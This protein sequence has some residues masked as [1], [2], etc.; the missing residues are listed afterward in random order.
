[1]YYDIPWT[2]GIKINSELTITCDNPTTV[3]DVVDKNGKGHL[4]ALFGPIR[5]KETY[6]LNW[7]Y[8]LATVA[9][10]SRLDWT[11]MCKLKFAEVGS[12]L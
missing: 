4:T 2:R 8:L 9:C 1:M 3:Y 10:G 12:P 11:S 7:L 5:R 6:S